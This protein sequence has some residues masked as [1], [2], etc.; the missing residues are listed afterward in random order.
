MLTMLNQ[1]EVARGGNKA[2]GRPTTGGAPKGD[3][4]F[5]HNTPRFGIFYV[6]KKRLITWSPTCHDT[7]ASDNE[8]GK[9]RHWKQE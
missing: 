3:F 4:L 9:R 1:Q 2:Y 5:T 6:N 8:M 7:F